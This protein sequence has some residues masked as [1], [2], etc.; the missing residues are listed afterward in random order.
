MR[1]CSSPGC[2]RKVPDNVRWC[3]ECKPAS[4]VC[5]DIRTHTV[6]DKARYQFLYE[7]N[8]FQDYCRPQTFRK[9]PFCAICQRAPSVICDHIVPAGEAI[10]QVQLSGRFPLKRYAG[11]YLLNNLQGLCRSCH[12]IKTNEDKAHVGPWPS[13][14]DK[15]DASPTKVWRF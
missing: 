6:S 9:Y 13:V 12:G 2:G 3:D 7:G 8:R 15:E 1:Q 11:F 14:L 4:A 10:R 5:D